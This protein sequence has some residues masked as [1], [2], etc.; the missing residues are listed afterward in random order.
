MK[1][2][3]LP[4]LLKEGAKNIWI[5]RT[6][7]F[8]SVAVLVSCLLLTGAAVLLSMN[9]NTAMASVEGN[10]SIKVYCEQGLP[11]LRSVQVG[12][13]IMKLE[14]I[15]S[16]ELIL[17]DEA[18]EEMLDSLGD[19]G[20][21]L[22]SLLG[23][24]NF[25]PDAFRISMEDLSLYEETAQ[26]IL[27]IDGVEQ[28]IDYKDVAEK[29]TRLDEMVSTAGIWIVVL[30]SLVSLFIISN[31]IRVAMFSRRL[32]ISIMKSVGATNWF[33]RFPFIVEGILIGLLSGVFASLLLNVVYGKIL[34]A[35]SGINLFTPIDYSVYQG[36]IL[37]IFIAAGVLFGAL[38]GTISITRYLRK[39]GSFSIF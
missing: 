4:F 12:E 3:N 19:N 37:M 8:A 27:A 14:N 35:I 16:C 23:D 18:V 6:M 30:L 26:Q 5:N 1:L 11:T 29:L 39:E 28:I 31:T 34:E 32:E 36:K 13:E 38:G 20:T 9:I 17:K 22:E 10:N 7:S 25:L 33:I 2:R 21:V 15:K 24:D